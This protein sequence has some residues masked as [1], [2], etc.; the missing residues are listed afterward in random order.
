MYAHVLKQSVEQ[1]LKQSI[2]NTSLFLA[3]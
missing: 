1:T 2:S 3:V